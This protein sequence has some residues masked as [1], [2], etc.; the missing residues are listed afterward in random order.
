[1]TQ[2]ASYLGFT[3]RRITPLWPQANSESERFMRV[4]GKTIQAARISGY[5]LNQSITTMLRNY[6]ATPHTTTGMPPATLLLGRILKVKIPDKQS[7][8]VPNELVTR[9]QVKKDKMNEYVSKQRHA[10]DRALRVGDLVLVKQRKVTKST[11]PYEPTPYRIVGQKGTLISARNTKD[12]HVITRNVSFFKRVS[13]EV[14]SD[15]HQ[16]HQSTADLP[17]LDDDDILGDTAPSVEH[18]P[19]RNPA[20]VRRPP[21]RYR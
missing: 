10:C 1:M 21:P 11:P 12:D 13:P 8:N 16:Y 6:R 2:F 4:I 14:A 18:Y 7:P 20:R 5:P 17:P 15:C 19:R 3:H 9:S